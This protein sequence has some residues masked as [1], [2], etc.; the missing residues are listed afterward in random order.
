MRIMTEQNFNSWIALT[1]DILPTRTQEDILML[2]T[3]YNSTPDRITDLASSIVKNEV[4][5]I[6]SEDTSALG[7]IGSHGF[8]FW[9]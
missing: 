1:S 9:S 8:G 3:A 2:E 7:I 6:N 5:V 4:E